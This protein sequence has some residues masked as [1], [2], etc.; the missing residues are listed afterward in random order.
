V[1]T[2]VQGCGQRS[3]PNITGKSGAIIRFIAMLACS[4]MRGLDR[5]S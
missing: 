5:F 3:V 2:E 4:R 1:Q